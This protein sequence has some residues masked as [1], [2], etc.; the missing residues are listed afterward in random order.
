MANNT[1]KTGFFLRIKKKALAVALAGLLLCVLC[2]TTLAYL[3]TGTDPVTQIFYPATISCRVEM[4]QATETIKRDARVANNG[5]AAV[6]I[7]V[8]A[9]VNWVDQSGKVSAM[10]P[11]EGSDYHIG[12]APADHIVDDHQTPD[13]HA[14]D[15]VTEIPSKWKLHTDGYWYYTELVEPGAYT[16]Y[17]FD[18]CKE[19][20]TGAPP[21]CYLSV[22]LFAQAIQ[23]TPPEA[24]K[25]AW[26][27]DL[28]ALT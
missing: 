7:R 10:T 23:A 15:T 16:G 19:Y 1:P 2:D 9:V 14:D 3:V 4:E 8:A 28:R 22:Q 27:V 11:V 5:D 25:D 24:V 6:Y 17:L 26:G 20:G 12:W 13:D 18:F 21:N